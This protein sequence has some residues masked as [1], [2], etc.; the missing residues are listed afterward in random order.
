MAERRG[1]PSNLVRNDTD[2]VTSMGLFRPSLETHPARVQKIKPLDRGHA[3]HM[4]C[5]CERV[6]RA[7]ACPSP[8]RRHATSCPFLLRFSGGVMA[9][10]MALSSMRV[11]LV[12]ERK[13]LRA[14][15]P[16]RTCGTGRRSEA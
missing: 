15:S 7:L 5:P 14:G 11:G 9:D 10:W 4:V 2:V 8:N 6:I 1:N 16:T 13:A 3:E 12:G